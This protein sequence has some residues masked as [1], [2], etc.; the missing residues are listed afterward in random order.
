[1][2]N[3][4]DLIDSHIHCFKEGFGDDL[5]KNAGHINSGEHLREIY[6]ALNVSGAIVMSN[7]SLD[8]DFH[9][10]PDFIRYC[11]GLDTTVTLLME[12]PKQAY[13]LVEKNLQSKNCVG[14]KLY[15]GYNH[16]YVADP[17]YHPIYH[18]AQ[19]YN[20]PVAIHTGETATPFAKLS[21]SHPLTLDD[22]AADFPNVNFVMCHFGNPWFNDAAAVLSKNKN[23]SADL[24]GL[25]VGK[26]DIKS[27]LIEQK[28]YVD[29]L[30]TWIN[31]VGYDRL[32]FGTD[33][34]LANLESYIAFGKEIIPEKHWQDFFANNARRI[35]N[36]DF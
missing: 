30:K 12:D 17:I 35:Y 7:R 4:L 10:Y 34:P 6:K 28:G 5:A 9:D 36:L 24:S 2:N 13:D 20:K 31:Y 1:M 3:N 22:V 15:P 21:Y 23:V 19:K 18:L 25:L 33:W 8:L 26:V 11:I 16:H 29:Y 27:F 14:I 32:M